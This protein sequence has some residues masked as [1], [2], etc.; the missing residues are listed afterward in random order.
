MGDMVTTEDLRDHLEKL[1]VAV[2]R[3]AERLDEPEDGIGP[4]RAAG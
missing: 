1:T 3:I 4:H 2:Q